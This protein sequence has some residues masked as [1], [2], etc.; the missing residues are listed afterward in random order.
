MIP[1]YRIW[2][3]EYSLPVVAS[4]YENRILFSCVPGTYHCKDHQPIIP[5]KCFHHS[6]S[7][8][9]SHTHSSKRYTK[10]SNSNGEN[11]LA[12]ALEFDHFEVLGIPRPMLKQ[13]R[14]SL[15]LHLPKREREKNEQTPE[16][17]RKRTQRAT[18]EKRGVAA[19]FISCDFGVESPDPA[20]GVK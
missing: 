6:Q 15:W 10:K 19:V 5:P 17:G 7:N 14:Y 11:G 12:A 2:Q 1:Q 20:I 9:T 13:P 8:K 3:I 4:K 18:A 16:R